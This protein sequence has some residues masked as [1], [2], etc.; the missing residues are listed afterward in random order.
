MWCLKR[1]PGPGTCRYGVRVNGSC[2]I[3]TNGITE[4]QK[5]QYDEDDE[6]VTT[7]AKRRES[8]HAPPSTWRHYGHHF[9]PSERGEGRPRCV[10]GP[11]PGGTPKS[12]TRTPNTNP[13]N[14]PRN[15]NDPLANPN[16]NPNT[17]YR[18]RVVPIQLVTPFLQYVARRVVS[19][20]S[21]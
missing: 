21:T 5:Q 16:R 19:G 12:R 20:L 6:M 10:V 3:C 8:C 14:E 2:D 13:E 9:R 11:R 17:G 4:G 7:R 18:V 1:T 15:E